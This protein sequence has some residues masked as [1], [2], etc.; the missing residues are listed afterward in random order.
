MEMSGKHCSKTSKLLI[1]KIVSFCHN[2]FK[3]RR[4]KMHYASVSWKGLNIF[5]FLL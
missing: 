5:L 4:L 2:V 3:T 1:M